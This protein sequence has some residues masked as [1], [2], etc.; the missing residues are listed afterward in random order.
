[1]SLGRQKGQ[2]RK[3]G[4]TTSKREG[5]EMEAAR[6]QWERNPGVEG[7]AWGMGSQE[8]WTETST[9]QRAF[10]PS[11]HCAVTFLCFA[12]AL[13]FHSLRKRGEMKFGFID[14]RYLVVQS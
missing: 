7:R 6:G 4:I 2:M 3:K 14:V 10:P 13:S 12:F 1:M 5:K 11:R 9:E 8:T